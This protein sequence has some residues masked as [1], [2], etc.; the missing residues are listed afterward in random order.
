[1]SFETKYI[2][3][4]EKHNLK[5]GKNK[6]EKGISKRNKTDNPKKKKILM[7][8]NFVIGYFDVVLFMKQKAKKKEKERKRQKQGSKIKQKRKTG[9]K[10]ERKKK[11]RQRKSN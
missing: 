2:D 3:V 11:E 4:E 6:D 1:M 5:S 7:K 10:K 8:K 9:R